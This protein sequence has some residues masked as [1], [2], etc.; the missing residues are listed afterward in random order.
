[1]LGDRLRLAYGE[2]MTMSLNA[3]RKRRAGLSDDGC[4]SCGRYRLFCKN[5]CLE[6]TFERAEAELDDLYIKALVREE[7]AKALRVVR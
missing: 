7:V 2:P 4:C 6:T 3:A 5:G 1:M